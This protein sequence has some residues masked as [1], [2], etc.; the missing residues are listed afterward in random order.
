[1]I[2]KVRGKIFIDG[3]PASEIGRRIT[4]LSQPTFREVALCTTCRV[5]K[6]L[7]EMAVKRENRDGYFGTCKQCEKE[8]L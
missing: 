8:G 6:T 7:P 4:E 3:V 2:S 5:L 1:M